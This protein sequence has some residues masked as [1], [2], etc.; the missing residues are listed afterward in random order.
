MFGRMICLVIMVI[1][2]QT[3]VGLMQADETMIPFKEKGIVVNI[4]TF[5]EVAGKS[6][7]NFKITEDTV[8]TYAFVTPTGVYAFLETPTNA[9]KLRGIKPGAHVSLTGKLLT[10]GALL[11][12]ETIELLREKS[13]IDLEK[14]KKNQGKPVILTGKNI[15]LCNLEIGSLSTQCHVGHSHHLATQEG[16]IYHYLQFME[17]GTDGDEL[18]RGVG[19]KMEN[20]NPSTG[21]A[22]LRSVNLMSERVTVKALELPGH[23]LWIEAW[24]VE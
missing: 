3:N 16:N 10:A 4:H 22:T 14:F 7:E 12:I 15:C 20:F 19:F 17:G 1:I 11:N 6:V 13:T 5:F 9:A 18:F 2:C 21:R 24:K 23:Y 8:S